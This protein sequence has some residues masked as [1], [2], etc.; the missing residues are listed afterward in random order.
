MHQLQGYAVVLTGQ[1]PWPVCLHSF[2]AHHCAGWPWWAGTFSLCPHTTRV[3]L[4]K[5][6]FEKP[7]RWHVAVCS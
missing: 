6:A 5:A 7:G 2:G 3:W 1:V 4:A